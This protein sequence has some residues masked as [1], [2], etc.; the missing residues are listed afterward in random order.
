MDRP[1]IV[2]AQCSTCNH[3]SENKT[4]FI[5]RIRNHRTVNGVL[6]RNLDCNQW[7]SIHQVTEKPP[8]VCPTCGQIIRAAEEELTGEQ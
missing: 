5:G 7:A 8:T 2:Q 4:C 6:Y 1:T 3:H